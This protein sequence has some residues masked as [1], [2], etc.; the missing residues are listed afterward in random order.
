MAAIAFG[1]PHRAA[2]R[3]NGLLD[4]LRSMLDAFVSHRMRTVAAEAEQARAAAH[5]T[6]TIEHLRDAGVPPD[7]PTRIKTPFRPLDP[8][9]V[10][11]TI[12]AFFIGRTC[13][14]FWIARDVKGQA[15]GI[16]LLESSALSFARK[17]SEPAGCVTIFPS[18]SIELD[19]ANSGNALIPYLRSLIQLATRRWRR[20][21]PASEE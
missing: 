1:P 10:S 11:E 17:H 15:G 13:D 4:R 8:E 19:L 2:G 5:P 9:I 12:P 14:G 6:T 3:P 21:S 16:F 18:K 20:R 7:E